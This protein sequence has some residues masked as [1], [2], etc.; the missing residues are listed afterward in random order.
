MRMALFPAIS[1]A[2]SFAVSWLTTRK[3]PGKFC[4]AGSFDPLD[5]A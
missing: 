5:D 1:S 2:L 4:R 3:Q